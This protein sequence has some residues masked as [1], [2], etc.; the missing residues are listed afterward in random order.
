MKML[1]C[2]LVPADIKT[3]TAFKKNLYFRGEELMGINNKF[4]DE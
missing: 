3:I 2:I 4:E 1:R